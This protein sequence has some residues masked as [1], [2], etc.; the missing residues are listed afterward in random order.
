MNF[1]KNLLL[2]TVMA[3]QCVF[4]AQAVVFQEIDHHKDART[5]LPSLKPFSDQTCLVVTKDKNGLAMMSTGLLMDE[6]NIL[7]TAHSVFDVKYVYALFGQ[8]IGL[9]TKPGTQHLDANATWK[10]YK[11]SANG[12]KRFTVKKIFPLATFAVSNENAFSVVPMDSNFD[13]QQ[14]HVAELKATQEDKTKIL[15]QSMQDGF[16]EI[17]VNMYKRDGPDLALLKMKEPFEGAKIY[18]MRAQQ[19]RSK[20]PPSP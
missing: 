19:S 10:R 8:Q 12:I 6:E 20:T 3:F 2:L 11:N 13:E 7:T 9:V 4:T 17:G 5:V 18:G 1:T 15:T 16:T 14:A